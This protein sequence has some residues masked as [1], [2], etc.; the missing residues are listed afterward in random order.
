VSEQVGRLY[1]QVDFETAKLISGQREIDKRVGEAA[2]TFNRITQAVKLYA[3]ALALLKQINIAEEFRL[4][5]VRAEVAAGSVEAGARAMREL[6]RISVR[7]Q[8]SLD[9]NV[10]VFSR[11]NQSMLQLGGTQEDTLR[12]NEL[13]GKAIK[14]SGASATEARSAMLQFGQALGS[15]K[16]AGDELRS[17]M[18]NA[19]YLMQRLAEG[20]QVPIGALKQLGEDG[21]LTSD[22]VVNALS[23][24]AEKIEADFQKIPRTF[25]GAV[26]A[27]ADSAGRAAERL[28]VV[29]G[30]SALAAGAT[31]G[32]SRV[33][34]ML[35]QQFADTATES[36]KLGRNRAV[37]TWADKTQLALTYL[38][39]AVDVV[40]QT[41]SVLGRNV[42]FVLE[43]LG[44]QIGGVS[45]MVAAAAR[46]DL[47]QAR[48]IWRQMNAD[49]ERRRAELD[50]RDAET[51][52]K[53]LLSGERMR[54]EMAQRRTEDR[55][56]TPASPGSKLRPPPGG[57]GGK[58][59]FDAEG[60]LL[61]LQEKTA[62]AYE[63][64]NVIEQRALHKAD[65]LRRAG[66]L[67]A[68]QYEEARSLIAMAAGHDRAELVEREEREKADLIKR[69]L[70]EVQEAE[71][72]AAEERKRAIEYAAQLTKAVNPVDALRQEYEAKLDLV[73]QYEQMI[74][75]AGVDATAQAQLARTQIT[76]EYEL[77]RQALAEQSFRSQSDANAFLM[78]SIN[79][80]G[81]S[82]TGAIV[83]LINGTG[84]ATDAVR[85]L[86]NVVLNEAVGALVQVG[87][88]M[89]K[90]AVLGNTLA[91][92]DKAKAAANAAVYT[93]SVTAQVA[94]MSAMAAQNAFAATAA[95]PIVGPALAPAAAAAAAAAAS[96]LGAPAVATA[97]VAGARQYGG[98]VSAG[99]LYRVNEGGRPEMFTAGGKQ[100]M[101]P[102]AD[103]RVTPSR[104]VDR[105]RAGNSTVIHMTNNFETSGQQDR[106]SNLQMAEDAFVMLQR[107]QR[108]L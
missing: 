53:R 11:L 46:G 25:S 34:D 2:L 98:P 72:V 96:A 24:A 75:A 60:Y 50:R 41:L 105:S 37:E 55:G 7:T 6:E 68:Q 47:A 17:L 45:A 21:K 30:S 43:T 107:A 32:L 104:D 69:G 59:K 100:F 56:F 36:D 83:G 99:E 82:A 20:L 5:S 73:K 89:L 95:I 61:G 77:Q 9:S 33:L 48:E 103:G 58:N 52:R 79:S 71:K 40:W 14:V 19:P 35:A 10:A 51:L 102:T 94:G 29:T 18:E 23:K 4:L 13:L 8:T 80:L 57:D 63:R 76:R 54:Q 84:S 85:A 42:Y 1:Y 106:R 87:V 22:V 90:N 86:G 70:K 92:A 44:S 78:N 49:D 66:K 88:Q 74:A 39:D 64:I 16:L 12:L 108:N 31:T 27:L 91:A 15:G 28:D 67:N 26:T 101:L 97:P 65:E 62:D 38:A 81:Q 3:A 93:A